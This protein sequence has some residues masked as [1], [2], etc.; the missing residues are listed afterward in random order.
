M[1]WNGELP[2]RRYA[3]FTD[4]LCGEYTTVLTGRD[5]KTAE[6]WGGFVRWLGGVHPAETRNLN[7]KQ[8]KG[9]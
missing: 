1:Y 9:I 3:I 2:E 6:K 7:G 8:Y 4:I 5:T